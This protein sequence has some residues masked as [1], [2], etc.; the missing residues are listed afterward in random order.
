MS[1]CHIAFVHMENWLCALNQKN[2]RIVPS[3]H[4]EIENKPS[5][6]LKSLPPRLFWLHE[7][8]S[9]VLKSFSSALQLWPQGERA[10]LRKKYGGG[11]CLMGWTL[12]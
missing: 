12:L 9:S 2:D 1:E 6:I 5:N 7:I 10:Y 4:S 3:R 8:A 11:H